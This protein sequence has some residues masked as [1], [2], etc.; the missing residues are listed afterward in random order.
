MDAAS[1]VATCERV[2]QAVAFDDTA[3]TVTFNLTKP[4]GPFLQLLTS[5][6][7]S[8]V[9]ME[10]MIDQGDWDA[11]CGTWTQWNDPTADES[12]IFNTMNGTGPF[13]FERWVPAEE[14]S[15]VRNDNY[16]VTEPLWEGGPSGPAALDRVVRKVVDEW[17]TR[18]S[19]FKAGDADWIFVP[20][21]FLAQ[22]D[23]LVKEEYEGGEKDGDKLTITNPNGIARLF[24]NLPV[25]SA[26]DAYFVFQVNT[27][28]GNPFVGS[29]ALDGLGI[30]P[31]FFSDVNVRRGFSYAFDYDTYIE[32]IW[33]G[34]ALRRT[35]PII[36]GHIGQSPDQPLY[37]FDLEKAE[38]EFR[39]A[40]DGQLWDTGFFL[41]LTYN[42]GNDQR[43][44]AAEI[45][46]DGIESINPAFKVAIQEV[47]FSTYLGQIFGQRLPLFFIGWGEDY[48]HPNAWVTPYL[49]SQGT[50]A[51]L[52]AF[53]EEL[54]QQFDSGVERCVVLGEAEA[55]GCYDELQRLAYESAIDI[56]ITQPSERHYQQ[57]WMDGWF[58]NPAY[59]VPY[60]WYYALSK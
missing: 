33:L 12:V 16:W 35:G 58:L 59:A 25:P 47:P 53:P 52:Q 11:D 4:F 29:G 49:H 2:E 60:L 50:I 48:H 43:R 18:L 24:K 10:W 17:G 37:A 6:Y 44:V 23:P 39:L 14:W 5:T 34:N 56:F 36:S 51:G 32:D 19:M 7:G 26:D 3:G 8:I 31:D 27:E 1:L 9:D 55:V 21:Q 40:L 20:Q 28:G 13:K 30:P 54:Q 46:E 57:L 41:V 45:L 22:I 38:E 15:I 42:S